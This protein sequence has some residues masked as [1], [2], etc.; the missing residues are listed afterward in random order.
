LKKKN[1]KTSM[2]KK[3]LMLIKKWTKIKNKLKCNFLGIF[4]VFLPLEL[5]FYLNNQC[6]QYFH[7][8]FRQLYY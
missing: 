6:D 2:K 8:T 4:S 5:K 7:F 3:T 1:L